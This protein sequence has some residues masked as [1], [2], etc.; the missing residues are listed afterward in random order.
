MPSERVLGWAA[1]VLGA[2]GVVSAENVSAAI[3]GLPAR[4]ACY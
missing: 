2:T 3:T 4:F 1:D